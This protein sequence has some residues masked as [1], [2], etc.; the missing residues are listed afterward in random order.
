MVI[1]AV[2]GTLRPT[3]LAV[4]SVPELGQISAAVLTG[5]VLAV[6]GL[7]GLTSFRGS[8]IERSGLGLQLDDEPELV[9]DPAADRVLDMDWADAD[10]ARTDLRETV[11]DVLEDQHGY[12][13]AVAK[14]AIAEGEWTG[15]R[16]AA[17]VIETGLTYPIL[18]R[19]REW[20]EDEGTMERRLERTIDA[21]EALHEAE[22]AP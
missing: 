7:Y 19:L 20:F 11:E 3:L 17:A 9:Q 16:V 14:E 22:V 21:I 6:L 10:T 1:A 12:S 8:G 4:L 5:V 15:D 13:A 2:A 18:E